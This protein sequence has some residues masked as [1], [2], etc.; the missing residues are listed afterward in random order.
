MKYLKLFE[1]FEAQA[2]SK[3]LKYLSKKVGKDSSNQFKESLKKIMSTYDIPID[4]IKESDVKYLS[5]KQ[6]VNIKN[7]EKVEN[8]YGIYCIKFWFSLEKGFIGYTGV[9]NTQVDFEDWKESRAR[10]YSTGQNDPFNDVELDYIKSE[11]NITTGLLKPVKRSDY[12]NLQTGDEVIAFWDNDTHLYNYKLGLGKIWRDEYGRI[13]GIQNTTSG[14]APDN[15]IQ[16]LN[17]E[18][19]RWRSLGNYS[20][21]MGNVNS[22]ADDHK[23]LHRY[24]RNEEPISVFREEE[25]VKTKKVSIY[26]FNL[27]ISP[28][29]ELTNWGSSR[30]IDSY[31]SIDESDF[32]V[33]FYIDN[34]LDPDKAEFYESPSEIKKQ[35]VEDKKGA[36]KLLSDSEIKRMNIERYLKAAVNKMGIDLNPDFQNL[37]NIVKN[38]TCGDFSL[39]SLYTDYPSLDFISEFSSTLVNL[40]KASDLGDKEYYIKRSASIYKNSKDSKDG[41]LSRYKETMKIINSFD[42]EETKEFI[43]KLIKIGDF[44]KS[45]IESKNIKTLEDL[46]MIYYKLR[47]VRSLILDSDFRFNNYRNIID[48][49]FY[50]SDAGLAC[51]RLKEKRRTNPDTPKIEKEDYKKLENIERYIKSILN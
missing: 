42:D 17:G 5:K 41:A 38:S 7:E 39:F 9:G 40:L 37:Q 44:I 6:A 20:W 22:P 8:S 27:P 19:I 43:S 50:P 45:Y 4:K 28:Y 35:R 12:L 13:Y 46:K 32:C 31:E 18:Q 21:D 14:G 51:E 30:T 34:M 11:L 24:I 16:E 2:L 26:D 10:R 25:E 47:S 3:V 33:V 36:T 29:G 1:A 49:L 23:K 48:E 15:N